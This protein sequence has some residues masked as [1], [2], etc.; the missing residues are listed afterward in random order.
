MPTADQILSGLREIANTW[1]TVAM[2][3]HVYF[4]AMVL[5]LAVGVRLSRRIAGL[6]L[7]FPLWSV[8]AIAWLSPNPFNGLINAVVGIV[9]LLVAVKLPNDNVQLSPKWSLVPGL[10]LFVVGWTYS[11]LLDTSSY[12]PYL[13]SAP[14]GTIPC[15][16][17]TI[18]IGSALIL[19]VFGSHIL[20]VVLGFA[21]LLY[22]ILGVAYLHADERAIVG[23]VALRGPGG[24]QRAI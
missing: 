8:S 20:G 2:L 24:E 19:D 17:L 7:G 3:W 6:L 15:L 1:N 9:L 12:W 18:V 14:V 22:G 10:I 21:G 11:Q 23:W 5:V 4:G 16:R 13:Y